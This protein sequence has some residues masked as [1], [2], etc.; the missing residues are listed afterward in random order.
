MGPHNYVVLVNGASKGIG[1]GIAK[2]LLRRSPFDVIVTCRNVDQAR[3]N[4]RSDNQGRLE[5]LQC[6]LSKESNIEAVAKAIQ[7]KYGN[8][9]IRMIINSAG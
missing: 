1:A 4:L 9:C 5:I 8:G 7:S 2:L 6:D 3:E